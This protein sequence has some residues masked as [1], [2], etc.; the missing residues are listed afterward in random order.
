MYSPPLPEKILIYRKNT[1]GEKIHRGV[2]IHMQGWPE[3]YIHT[4]HDRIYGGFL[5][6][7]TYVHRIYIYMVLANPILIYMVLANP[8]HI[9][10]VLANPIHIYMVLADPIRML[11][12]CPDRCLRQKTS[13]LT[14]VSKVGLGFVLCGLL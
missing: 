5:A 12:R 3:P 14:L 13:A 6:K 7:K 10:M 11:S 1:Q 8:I 9:Y 4:V 2:T